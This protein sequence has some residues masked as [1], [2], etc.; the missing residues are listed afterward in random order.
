MKTRG[1]CFAGLAMTTVGKI[2]LPT[3]KSEE[4]F[5]LVPQTFLWKKLLVLCLS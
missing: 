5:F 4:P 2:V 3:R 1:D